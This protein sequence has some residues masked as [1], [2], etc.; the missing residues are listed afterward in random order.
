MAFGLLGGIVVQVAR[1]LIHRGST[2]DMTVA[3]RFVA[4]PLAA[5]CGAAA[6]AFF[7][8]LETRTA[9]RLLTRR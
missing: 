3:Y 9:R 8:I 1:S 4:I 6:L 7:T 2:V 5:G